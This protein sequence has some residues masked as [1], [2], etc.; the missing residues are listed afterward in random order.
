LNLALAVLEWTEVNDTAINQAPL[1]LIP[2]ALT[3][4]GDQGYSIK[5]SGEEPIVNLSLWT[6]L[7]QQNIKLPE[8]EALEDANDVRE[9]MEGVQKAIKRKPDW[10]VK[11]DTYLG[12]YSFSKFTMYM[13]LEALG[14][15]DSEKTPELLQA[16]L[17]PTGR[18]A[19]T[20]D[21][22]PSVVF[23]PDRLDE[24]INWKDT[25]LVLDAD[26]SQMA[27]VQEV[28][29]GKS[30][31]V[32]GPPGTG[33]S[34]TISNLISELI[35]E[36][37]RVLFVAEKRAALDV[38]KE[39]LDGQGLGPFL[40]ELH[41]SKSTKK[42]V[43]AELQRA[44]YASLQQ[45]NMEPYHVEI[46][47]AR[48][49]LNA[50]ATAMRE[51][52]Y[53][54][55][56]PV[57]ELMGLVEQLRRKER[58]IPRLALQPG[59]HAD[60][61]SR[62]AGHS[63]VKLYHDVHAQTGNPAEH[64]WRGMRPAAL[65]PGQVQ[66]ILDD[67]DAF[68]QGINALSQQLEDVED[69]TGVQAPTT[70]EKWK[71]C[72]EA[73]KLMA[74]VPRFESALLR[75]PN[76][77]KSLVEA[78]RMV[79]MLHEYQTGWKAQQGWKL[80][81][82]DSSPNQLANNLQAAHGTF[83]ALKPSYRR[84]RRQ[85]WM[86]REGD[87]PSHS[88]MM[89]DLSALATLADLRSALR[90]ANA[91]MQSVFGSQWIGETSRVEVLGEALG[92]MKAFLFYQQKGAFRD[93]LHERLQHSVDVALLRSLETKVEVQLGQV[94]DAHV[95]LMAALRP[96]DDLAN[97]NDV[98]LRS[99]REYALDLVAAGES[100]YGWS[101]FSEWLSKTTTSI[102]PDAAKSALSGNLA[103]EDLKNAYEL[104]LL[105]AELDEAFRKRSILKSFSAP[106]HNRVVAEFQ[107]LDKR[108][109]QWSRDQIL[110]AI[111]DRQR[112]Y[113]GVSIPTSALGIL[114][115]E[116]NK[117][118]KNRSI[119]HLLRDASSVIQDL[120]PCFMMSPLSVAQFLE[121]GKITFD[122]VIFDEASQ[123]KPHDAL[124]AIMRA[125]QVVVCGDKH[126]LPPTSFFDNA[127]DDGDEN[128]DEEEPEVGKVGDVESLLQ[129]CE[130]RFPSHLSRML[131][132]HYRS[133]HESLI[134]ASNREFYDNQLLT[135][136]SSREN[137]DEFGL[138]F[139]HVPE[140]IYDRGR[141]KTNVGEAR[142]IAGDVIAFMRR[143]GTQRSLG[144]V[145]M[146]LAQQRCL[147]AQVDA[148][149]VTNPDLE[150][151]FD[152]EG[153][154]SFFIKNLETVQGDERDVILVS[155]GYGRDSRGQVSRN[156]GPVNRD[157]GERRLNVLFT[158]AREQ[159]VVY[160]GFQPTQLNV[161][162]NP[163]RGIQVLKLF[164]DYAETGRLPETEYHE[165]D[166]DSP[167]EDSV[168]ALL[169][170]H[171]YTVRSQVGQSGYRIDLAI[172]DPIN[173]GRYALGI[174]CDGAAYHSTR[175]AR[176]RDRLRQRVLEDKG[177]RIHRIWSTEWFVNRQDAQAKLLAAVRQAIEVPGEMPQ[178]TA[179]PT[180]IAPLPVDPPAP[181]EE[182]PAAGF[183]Q[184]EIAQLDVYV[185]RAIIDTSRSSLAKAVQQ[186]VDRESPV[187]VDVVV[188]RIARHAGASRVGS[189]IRETIESSVR[190]APNVMLKGRTLTT[191]SVREIV[192]REREGN[193]LDIGRIPPLEVQAAALQL[194]H[195]NG[196]CDTDEL[197]TATA[198]GFGFQRVK[199]ATK[200][201]IL[202][203]IEKLVKGGNIVRK[204]GIC[205]ITTAQTS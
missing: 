111:R 51:P 87:R 154:D 136:P 96:V 41:S 14:P 141:S 129:L 121:P 124:G 25:R 155:I 26:P 128:E 67:L 171:G 165:D 37:K 42:G 112:K 95:R 147:E 142:R 199:E 134:T 203:E 39:R 166:T 89:R 77:A 200:E 17:N 91:A 127:L 52:L 102:F 5:W 169:K 117:K 161:G 192:P 191:K 1:I 122:V 198:R 50:Y 106:G 175:V 130:S 86:H 163:P 64:P 92:W 148:L 181:Q 34:Q 146:S 180:I 46:E 74:R 85:I 49:T 185:S 76:A 152:P 182:L 158:R 36:G 16:L 143:H 94:C 56:R 123:V 153:K 190:L 15:G 138:R 90:Q 156:F 174:E 125:K 178:A 45:G 44:L 188:D 55:S 18:N 23:D 66:P 202:S 80:S 69:M 164:L 54:W 59:S 114:K 135:F 187:L 48:S 65:L 144:V 195:A 149:R 196:E 119:R 27:V 20:F 83:A 162:E 116:L 150:P 6:K 172:V 110:A 186:V 88:A 183:P 113:H 62:E 126:Q 82:L 104:A 170:D 132:W 4:S 19:E 115:M 72:Q 118:R 60:R 139:V 63:L 53:S 137:T 108:L 79:A 105:T 98:A 10:R 109:A 38:V 159:V 133:R 32:Q 205:R 35:A 194:L 179:A 201:T 103:P 151:L 29:F 101:L 21:P 75:N 107:D 47:A 120:K 24:S 12:F 167:F 61:A 33:K 9:L 57:Q 84:A 43:H 73:M 193:E 58:R 22:D 157:G 8:P 70:V 71:D 31:I 97:L 100:L 78:E 145:A 160:A 189:R 176:A 93:D 168:K 197:A 99:A 177:W 184:Y 204:E 30:M 2:V 81:V 140:S 11:S 40:L 28:K 7:A 68:A 173:P 13:D 3:R 131:K